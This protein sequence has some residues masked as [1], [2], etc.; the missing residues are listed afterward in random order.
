LPITKGF[1]NIGFFCTHSNTLKSFTLG[2]YPST[3]EEEEEEEEGNYI[4]FLP[5]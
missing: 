2:R 1:H 3:K 4:C 5:F